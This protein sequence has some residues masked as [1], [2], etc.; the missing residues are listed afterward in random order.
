MAGPATLHVATSCSLYYDLTSLTSIPSFSEYASTCL[1]VQM[2]HEHQHLPKDGKRHAIVGLMWA[3]I[4]V[5]C[6]QFIVAAAMMPR[7]KQL[8][9]ARKLKQQELQHLGLGGVEL[10]GTTVAAPS[11][12]PPRY[13]A[14]TAGVYTPLL[15][16]QAGSNPYNA[17]PQPSGDNPFATL[18]SGATPL[19]GGYID[20]TTVPPG[21]RY[22][23][24]PQ[25]LPDVPV[26]PQQ[27]AAV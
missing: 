3:C 6:V 4:G 14:N 25:Q 1:N 24:L 19:L 11:P 5:A 17:P 23:A 2:Y 8:R 16:P 21:G 27:L 15:P 26:P 9:E 20:S 12:P 22:T 18:G 13:P 7:W 10:F